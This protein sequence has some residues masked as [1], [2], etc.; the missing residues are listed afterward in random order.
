MCLVLTLGGLFRVWEALSLKLNWLVSFCSF[1]PALISTLSGLSSPP[2]SSPSAVSSP[3][4]NCPGTC[5]DT[6]GYFS[7]IQIYRI[8]LV[9]LLPKF[10]LNIFPLLVFQVVPL[11][12][13][14][15]LLSYLKYLISQFVVCSFLK[16]LIFSF[17]FN[18]PSVTPCLATCLRA[19]W[20]SLCTRFPSN[21]KWTAIWSTLLMGL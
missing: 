18:L 11:Q 16:F 6:A 1:L 13:P 12:Q 5:N 15:P 9:L 20:E 7:N 4:S 8:Y 10:L 3:P 2:S 21:T 19:S 14:H 17:F